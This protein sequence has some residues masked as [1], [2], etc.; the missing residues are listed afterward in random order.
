MA[1]KSAIQL[2]EEPHMSG[3]G[4]ANK[5]NL[6]LHS[7]QELQSRNQLHNKNKNIHA[8]PC[9]DSPSDLSDSPSDL[10]DLSGSTFLASQQVVESTATSISPIKPVNLLTPLVRLLLLV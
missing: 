6:N 4:D 3:L 1:D 9:R 10:S 7:P 2:L 8:M 5:N